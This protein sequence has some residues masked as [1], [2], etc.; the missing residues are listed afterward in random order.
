MLVAHD[1][2]RNALRNFLLARI[3]SAEPTG[4]RFDPPSSFDAKQYFGG[5]L[6]RFAGETEY[7]VRVR[8]DATA[9]PYVR[10]RPWHASQIVT[11]CSGG[12]IEVT[13]RLNN[14]I[15]IERRILACGA[16]AE[17]LAPVELRERLRQAAIAMAARYH[18]TGFRPSRSDVGEQ[19]DFPEK[20]SEGH[21][22]S[23]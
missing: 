18:E 8:L 12:E 7:D 16:H 21:S 3:Q 5:S 13:L 17:V 6:G 11:E 4:A 22:A 2:T 23:R 1:R 9:A 20:I 14:L 10:E 19:R 15:D